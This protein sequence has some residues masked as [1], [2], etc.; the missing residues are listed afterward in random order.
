LIDFFALHAFLLIRRLESH[1]SLIKLVCF[2]LNPKLLAQIIII[3]RLKVSAELGKIHDTVRTDSFLICTL[4]SSEV[5]RGL[6]LRIT[7]K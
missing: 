3:I 4:V 2:R 1:E 7:N 6:V 5:G